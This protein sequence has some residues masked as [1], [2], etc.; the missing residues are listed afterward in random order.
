[1]LPP[2]SYK[3]F[4]SALVPLQVFLYDEVNKKPLLLKGLFIY[5]A[6]LQPIRTAAEISLH[7]RIDPTNLP[8]L[9][10]RI[11]LKAKQLRELK[12]SFYEIA[13]K[14]GVHVTTAIRAYY[15]KTL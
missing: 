15:F 7:I 4:P 8:P 1:L 14:L 6:R 13:N 10:Q 9:Y 12:M 5:W 11:S 3:T 2:T